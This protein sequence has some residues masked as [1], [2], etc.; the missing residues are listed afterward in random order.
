[1]QSRPELTNFNLNNSETYRLTFFWNKWEIITGLKDIYMRI[2]TFL[3]DSRNVIKRTH[4]SDWG[5]DLDSKMFSQQE[6]IFVLFSVVQLRKAQYIY[7]HKVYVCLL[8]PREA[9]LV[10]QPLQYNVEVKETNKLLKAEL[11]PLPDGGITYQKI[12]GVK[13]SINRNDVDGVHFNQQWCM[14]KYYSI[15]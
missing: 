15:M 1:M 6:V 4:N 7:F 10:V 3:G 9:T 2:H 11:S 5:I 12:K 14:P 8:L 13:Q